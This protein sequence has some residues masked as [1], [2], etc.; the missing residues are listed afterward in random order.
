M[1]NAWTNNTEEVEK[2]RNQNKMMKTLMEHLFKE[3]N[4][5]REENEKLRNT[6]R[7][8]ELM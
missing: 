6:R 1:I 7:S 8:P 4:I 5:L 3:I 2:L